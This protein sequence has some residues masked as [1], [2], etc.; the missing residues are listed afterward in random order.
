MLTTKRRAK[1]C[2]NKIEM[3]GDIVEKKEG[4]KCHACITMCRLTG[5]VNRG[6]RVRGLGEAIPAAGAS[7]VHAWAL[8]CERV[9]TL[10]VQVEQVNPSYSLETRQ[11]CGEITTRGRTC[12]LQPHGHVQ[13][14]AREAWRNGWTHLCL[15]RAGPTCLQLAM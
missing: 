2:E 13:N 14:G 10:L 15:G 3:A 5:L 1:S 7:I 11:N 9:S 8:D 4:D 6:I 12:F